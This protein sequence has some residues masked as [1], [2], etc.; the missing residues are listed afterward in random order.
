MMSHAEVWYIIYAYIL[1]GVRS[2]I[3]RGEAERQNFL[4]FMIFLK[5]STIFS[6]ILSYFWTLR[7]RG[8][9][10][11]THTRLPLM[12]AS[13]YITFDN[14]KNSS[15]RKLFTASTSQYDGFRRVDSFPIVESIED[16][17]NVQFHL[18]WRLL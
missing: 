6:L 1:C 12:Y 9:R 17:E 14:V 13:L 10:R 4:N 8:G 11:C 2:A 3:I 15:Q 7:G 18:Y 5:I 16:R